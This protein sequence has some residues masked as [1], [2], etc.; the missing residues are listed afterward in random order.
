MVVVAAAVG[1]V[2]VLLDRHLAFADAEA[3]G[4]RLVRSQV[5]VFLSR[6][7]YAHRWPI[8]T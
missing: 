8:E 7:R 5:S 4:G 6:T 2:E 3:Q 1:Q